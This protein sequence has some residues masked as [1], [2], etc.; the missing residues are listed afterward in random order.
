MDHMVTNSS[1][2]VSL[3]RR[4]RLVYFSI[5]MMMQPEYSFVI[6]VLICRLLNEMVT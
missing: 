2:A 4:C 1:L 5:G 6:F 3:L